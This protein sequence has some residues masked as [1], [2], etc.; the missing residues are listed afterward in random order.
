MA[1]P[2][3]AKMQH[4][5]RPRSVYSGL[6]VPST[7]GR[8]EPGG[9]PGIA[10]SNVRRRESQGS[11]AEETRWSRRHGKVCSRRSKLSS[12]PVASPLMLGGWRICPGWPLACA[13]TAGGEA[14]HVVVLLSKAIFCPCHAS[15]MRAKGPRGW[16]VL[17]RRRCWR[18]HDKLRVYDFAAA[19]SQSW[20]SL[21]WD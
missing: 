7:E 1:A 12:L 14:T 4:S 3:S 8:P 17:R 20:D 11:S 18:F 2:R 13:T 10:L 21:F 16:K 19:N 6:V 9:V 5:K 15:R